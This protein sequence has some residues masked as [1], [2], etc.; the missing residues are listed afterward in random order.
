MKKRFFINILPLITTPLCLSATS[1]NDVTKNYKNA[2]EM[3]E[4]I[5]FLDKEI[6]YSANHNGKMYKNSQYKGGVLSL[7]IDG[8]IHRFDKGIGVHAGCSLIFDLR[9]YNYDNFSTFYGIDTSQTSA[10]GAKVV[11][12]S[13]SSNDLNNP[14]WVLIENDP[15]FYTN[16]DEAKLFTTNIRDKK[17]IKI[18]VLSNPNKRNSYNHFNFIYPLLYNNS[19]GNYK[20]FVIPNLT[21]LSTKFDFIKNTN[22]Y[23]DKLKNLENIGDYSKENSNE[24]YKLLFIQNIGYENLLKLLDFNEAYLECG[25]WLFNDNE[26]LELLMT[27]G[28]L[29]FNDNKDGW[30]KVFENLANLYHQYKND[31]I[32][33]SIDP[34]SNVRTSLVYKKMLISLALTHTSNRNGYG[35][36]DYWGSNNYSSNKYM[37]YETFKELRNENDKEDQES[38]LQELLAIPDE[39]KNKKGNE[40]INK[41]IKRIKLQLKNNEYHCK[42]DKM[43][44]DNLPVEYMRWVLGGL[45][46]DTEIKWF[47]YYARRRSGFDGKFSVGG[48]D[49]VPYTDSGAHHKFFQKYNLNN[50]ND[51]IAKQKFAEMDKKYNLSKF[52][53]PNDGKFRFWV[54]VEVGQVCGGISKHGTSMLISTGHPSTVVGQPGH[55]AYLNFSQSS[56]GI[57]TWKI[58]NKVGSWL[59]AEK[60]ERMPLN[61]VP[62][63]VSYYNVNYITLTYPVLKKDFTSYTKSFFWNELYK[64]TTKNEYTKREKLL[65]NALKENKYNYNAWIELIKLYKEWTIKTIEDKKQ[66]GFKLLDDLKNYPF[67]YNDLIKEI[68]KNENDAILK[69]ELN[70]KL[71]ENLEFDQNVKNNGDFIHASVTN[72]QARG[73]LNGNNFTL[74]T[75]SFSGENANKIVINEIYKNSSNKYRYSLNGEQTFK[76][77]FDSIIELND[78]E[79][80]ELNRADYISVGIIG[81]NHT[82]HINIQSQTINQN[83]YQINLDEGNLSG[84]KNN[85]LWSLDKIKWNSFIDNELRVNSK[86]NVFVKKH[87]HDNKKESNI[88]EYELNKNKYHT[89][90]IYLPSNKYKGQATNDETKKE[91]LSMKHLFD[92]DN[93]TAWHTN[94]NSQNEQ[95]IITWIFDEAID[96]SK[97]EYIP[98][99]IVHVILEAKVYICNDNS[100][101]WIEYGLINWEKNL[102]NKYFYF[103]QNTIIKK[104]KI[105]IIKTSNPNNRHASSKGFNIWLRNSNYSLILPNEYK[106]STNSQE[107]EKSNDSIQNAKNENSSI[108][109]TKWDKSIPN[110]Y[111]LFALDKTKKISKLTYTPRDDVS[112]G[113]ITSCKISYSIDGLNYIQLDKTIN[114]DIDS[115]TKEIIFDNPI[116]AK[117]IKLFD[118]V[119]NDKHVAAKNFGIYEQIPKVEKQIPKVE[120]QKENENNNSIVIENSNNKAII[121]I[122]IFG[123]LGFIGI[124]LAILF[125][126]RK[127]KNNN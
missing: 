3:M 40:Y 87:A 9:K 18:E 119:T 113:I 33:S 80:K 85:L 41:N 43:V 62:K 90:D 95:K 51:P 70:A 115:K 88:L 100:D 36:P 22:Y 6:I 42:I 110:P 82:Y 99:K 126:L 16:Q 44:F 15:K 67:V 122:S 69:L 57:P 35:F 54:A 124:L 1:H 84:D 71:K 32:D 5:N 112:S 108:W 79:I 19:F 127:R 31:L 59:V 39:E 86:T 77:T 34:D 60:G 23:F 114:W 91:N 11:F 94:Y 83:D 38:Y 13:S 109:H 14:N 26:T 81:S 50:P 66:L 29:E 53:I 92:G 123:S 65:N 106:I 7:K 56:N 52:N 96:I 17:F 76:E 101:N 24:L 98:F 116:E 61:W 58:D 28:N 104:L 102:K 25:K 73:I 46:S 93:T 4:V 27:G 117:Y 105:E 111:V 63:N 49:Y 118:F 120:T 12:Y 55:G 10:T 64:L 20:D 21:K 107:L 89:S 48:Y 2:T 72:E 78:Q 74:A 125:I 30:K 45:Y 103:K 97:I 47:N 8:A 37:R 75:F 68:L 121:L